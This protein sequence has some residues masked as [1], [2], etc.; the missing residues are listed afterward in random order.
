MNKQAI[1]ESVKEVARLAFFAA[2]TAIVGWASQKV[3]GLDPTSIHY[4]IG[5]L[6]LRF[7]DKYVHKSDMKANGI[8]PF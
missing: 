8:A 1:L 3:A 4:V 5:T 2:L 7:V 6:L